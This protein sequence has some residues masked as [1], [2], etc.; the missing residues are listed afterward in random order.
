VPSMDG[1]DGQELEFA[2]LRHRAAVADIAIHIEE[3]PGGTRL[4]WRVPLA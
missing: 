4:A 1:D 3:I 2:G